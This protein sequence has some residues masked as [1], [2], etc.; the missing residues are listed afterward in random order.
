MCWIQN[1]VTVSGKVEP[2]QQFYLGTILTCKSYILLYCNCAH[3]FLGWFSLLMQMY[4]PSLNL[5]KHLQRRDRKDLPGIIGNPLASLF[6]FLVTTQS[7][8]EFRMFSKA[9]NDTQKGQKGKLIL[10]WE[11]KEKLL[12]NS[13]KSILEAKNKKKSF[14]GNTSK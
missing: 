1:S 8:Q 7:Q 10:K 6:F 9:Q 13:K 11:F 2:P 3:H 12:T 4:S 14:K 5:T